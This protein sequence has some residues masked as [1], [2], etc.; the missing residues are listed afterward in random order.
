[1]ISTERQE[2]EKVRRW[3]RPIKVDYIFFAPDLRIIQPEKGKQ[4][5]NG[6][7]ITHIYVRDGC[8][9]VLAHM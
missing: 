8:Y 5:N 7:K 4:D 3:L 1:M 9:Q 2:P 6:N